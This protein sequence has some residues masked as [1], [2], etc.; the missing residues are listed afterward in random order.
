MRLTISGRLGFYVALG[1]AGM[2]GALLLGRPEPALL[3]LPFLLAVALGLALARP[4]NLR[5]AVRVDRERLIEGEEVEVAVEVEA[6]RPVP[7]LEV[8]LEVPAG[9]TVQRLDRSQPVGLAAGA[10][11][12]ERWR[13]APQRW[14]GRLRPR[15]EVRAR[16]SLGFFTWRL[17]DERLGPLRVYPRP[18]SL[19][20]LLAPAE[21]QIRA[22]NRVSRLRGDGV[23]FADVRPFVPGDRVRRINWRV[24][25]R[26]RELHVNEMR[27]ERNADVVIFIDTFAGL[28]EGATQPLGSTLDL[29]VRAAAALA[30]AYLDRRDRVGL[31]SF[32]GT[33]RWLRPEMGLRQAYRVADA[34]IDTQVVLS[35]AWKGLEV[36]PRRTIP[37]KSL[38]VAL[39]PML[40]DRSLGALLD[41][42]GRGHDLGLIE[43]SPFP[44]V[45]SG[46]REAEQVAYRLWEMER[47]ALR[48]RF[49]SL[50]VP[51][52]SWRRG[53]PLEPVLASTSAFRRQMERRHP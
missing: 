34:L 14:G 8:V 33:L 44:F 16:D 42:R 52:A 27:P 23:E 12:V 22:G 31:V 18:E 11:H 13:L 17:G 24:S 32:G 46:R 25:A 20:D 48:G 10:V 4:P 38:V 19:R 50:G 40:D 28:E 36:I 5:A 45:A 21:T 7:G 35:Y 37:A 39:T 51:I 26:R 6:L 3:V 43:V 2:L 30:R 1:T 49:L 29:V 47:E 41:L 9:T 15:V 53:E